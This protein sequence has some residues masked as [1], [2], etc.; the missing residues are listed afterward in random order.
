MQKKRSK[1]TTRSSSQQMKSFRVAPDT[2]PFTS[3]RPTKQTLY[4]TLL[5][6][7]IAFFQ[8]WI[9]RLQIE[10]A[11]LTEALTLIQQ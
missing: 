1:K 3:M 8:I 2:V 11:N 5:V 9:I 10:I 4:W 7:V 6:A